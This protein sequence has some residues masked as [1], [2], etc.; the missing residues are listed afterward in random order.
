MQDQEKCENVKNC[1]DNM[2]MRQKDE[3]QW[4]MSQMSHKKGIHT[5]QYTTQSHG[6]G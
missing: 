6:I 5:D 3:L 1:A 4:M 2:Q